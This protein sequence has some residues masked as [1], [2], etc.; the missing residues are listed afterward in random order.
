[1][2]MRIKYMTAAMGL[3]MTMGCN[4]NEVPIGSSQQSLLIGQ[5]EGYVEHLSYPSGSDVVHLSITAAT[6]TSVTGSITFGVPASFP[7]PTAAD[8]SYPDEARCMEHEQPPRSPIEG[9]S[10]TIL[11]PDVT[12]LR[13]RF[14]I[15]VHEP[16]QAYCEMQTPHEAANHPGEYRCDLGYNGYDYAPPE[17]CGFSDANG[18]VVEVPCCQAAW[19][20]FPNNGC[21]C[22]ASGCT[23]DLAAPHDVS[24]DLEVDGDSAD[25]TVLGLDYY[26][27][28]LEGP[29]Q[30]R[31]T[32]VQ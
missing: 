15:G 1:M 29:G 22:D 17:H 20:I 9:Y 32:R 23:V 25:G 14:G 11:D 7:A 31:L 13:I 2:R 4:Q 12:D 26:G 16:W 10:F 5:W 18:D 21:A 19:C 3:A 28:S 24:F 8:Q 27:E 30:L 6:A